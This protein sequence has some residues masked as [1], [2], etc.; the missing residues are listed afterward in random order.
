MALIHLASFCR[1][2]HSSSGRP[3]SARLGSARLE[4]R[5]T[6]ATIRR[7]VAG[8]VLEC[9]DLALEAFQPVYLSMEQ[10]YGK[11]LFDRLRPDWETAEAEMIESLCDADG[12]Q[13]LVATIDGSVIGFI[14]ATPDDGTGLASIDIVSVHP[15]EQ[16]NGHGGRLINRC[17]EGLQRSGMVYVQAYL[18]DF[19]G[20]EPARLS[21]EKAGFASMPMQPMPLH[22]KLNGWES[23]EESPSGIRPIADA[24]VA[25][26]VRFGL[27]SFRPV[28]ASFK[29][30]HGEDVF[31]RMFPNW[32]ITQAKYIESACRSAD[33]ETWVYE[34]DGAVSGLLVLTMDDQMLG[35]IELLAVDP[36]KQEHGIGTA[37]NQFGVNRLREAGMAYAIVATANDPGHAAARRS[38]EKVGFMPMPIQWNFLI[39]KL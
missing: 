2:G 14:V 10:R 12:K 6:M 36:D 16:R 15:D 8:D 35:D 25:G 30:Q 20:H 21:F 38:Y 9:V 39:A 27:E 3:G 34:M 33:R 5:Y 32:E 17:L 18:R 11:D 23:S 19:P 28:F 4:G 1:L 26:C 7:L 13:S 37:L 22:M 31:P 24:D 29:E